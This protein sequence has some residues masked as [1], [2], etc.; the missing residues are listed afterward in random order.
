MP[1][2]QHTGYHHRC[3]Q[4]HHHHHQIIQEVILKK[5]TLQKLWLQ[6]TFQTTYLS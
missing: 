2:I 4:H 6:A 1:I 3:Y 5:K